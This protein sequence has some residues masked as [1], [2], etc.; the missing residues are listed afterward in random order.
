MTESVSVLNQALRHEEK[1]GNGGIAP[2]IPN[3]GT[4]RD[5]W[6][7][8]HSVRFIDIERAPL[9]FVEEK[10]GYIPEPIWM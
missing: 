9:L 10:A 4:I 2:H 7:A 3:V 8:S 5:H 6:S 1:W